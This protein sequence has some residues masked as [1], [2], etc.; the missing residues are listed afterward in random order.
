MGFNC[1]WDIALPHTTA[2]FRIVFT[3]PFSSL[4]LVFGAAVGWGGG[5][6]GGVERTDLRQKVRLWNFPHV[7]PLEASFKL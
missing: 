6:G 4:W 1:V 3:L 7:N 5:V 2:E